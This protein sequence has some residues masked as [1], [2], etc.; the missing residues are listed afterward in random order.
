LPDR[1]PCCG[2]GCVACPDSYPVD[3][4]VGGSC[5]SS[6]PTKDHESWGACVRAKGLRVGWAA[7]ATDAGMDAS[8]QKRNDR[9]LDL[10][11][12]TRAQGIQPDNTSTPAIRRAI[13]ASDKAG[14]AYVSRV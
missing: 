6:C 10:Y 8:F 14:A 1:E 12:R 4:V 11:A 7:S 3:A 9:E 2:L 13:E 5:S